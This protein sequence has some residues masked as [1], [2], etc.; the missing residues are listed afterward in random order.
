MLAYSEFL[1][2]LLITS[3]EAV[4]T[5]PVTVGAV[6]TNPD[7]SWGLLM[8]GNMIGSIPTMLLVYPVWRFMVRGLTAGAGR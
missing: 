3:S 8:A 1:I 7:V 6:S 4:R 5:L 2:A